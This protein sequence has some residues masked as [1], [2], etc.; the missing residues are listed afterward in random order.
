MKN[1]RSPGGLFGLLAR[2][3]LLFTLTLLVIIAG[4]FILW[5]IYIAQVYAPMNWESLLQDPALA[6]GDFSAL[7]GHLGKSG[8][9]FAVY[10]Q[11]GRLTYASADDFDPQLSA[12]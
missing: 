10:D 3:Y 5:G 2:S 11:R 1:K 8:S 12:G 7:E 6:A 4:V 9:S